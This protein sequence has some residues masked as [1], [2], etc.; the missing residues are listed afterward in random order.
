MDP[1]EGEKVQSQIL[2]QSKARLRFI[3]AGAKGAEQIVLRVF[4]LSDVT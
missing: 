4:C 2:R 1:Q 3:V